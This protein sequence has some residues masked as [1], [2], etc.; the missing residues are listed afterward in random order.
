[1]NVLAEGTSVC[2]S[3]LLA[4]A[5]MGNLNGLFWCL[6]SISNWIVIWLENVENDNA[7]DAF[8]NF[9]DTPYYEAEGIL[10]PHLI[11]STH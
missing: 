9:H 10:K 8:S 5:K 1:M 3:L 7:P 6:I 4:G 11:L 2:S